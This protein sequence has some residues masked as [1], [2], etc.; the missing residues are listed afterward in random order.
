[1]ACFLC[2]AGLGYWLP[3]SCC[4]TSRRQGFCRSRSDEAISDSYCW[5]IL[6]LKS[7]FRSMV[8]WLILGLVSPRVFLA[9]CFVKSLITSGIAHCC[10]LSVFRALFAQLPWNGEVWS[11]TLIGQRLFGWYQSVWTSGPKLKCL[12]EPGK[13]Y[14]RG[15]T[16]FCE[17]LEV[18]R[19]GAILERTG[20][21]S[22]PWSSDAKR[23]LSG[24]RKPCGAGSNPKATSLWFL[25]YESANF[26]C[27][28]RV[29]SASERS[30]FLDISPL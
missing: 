25:G 7:G 24:P 11:S 2:Q 21:V 4:V 10:G 17:Q 26:S 18:M 12:Q 1:M 14:E 23:T 9:S 30:H 8:T 5:Q 15:N 6:L 13:K 27:H 19:P 20:P 22:R 29:C 3:G 28:W 16:A